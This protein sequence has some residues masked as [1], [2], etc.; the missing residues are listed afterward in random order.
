MTSQTAQ[1][2][3]S[4]EVREEPG[5]VGVSATKTRYLEHQD[6]CSLEKSSCIKIR[7]LAFFYVLEDKRIWVH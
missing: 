1:R 3:P 5:Y 4:E 7:N 6:Y 2:D